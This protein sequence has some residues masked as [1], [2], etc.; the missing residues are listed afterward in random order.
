MSLGTAFYKRQNTSQ[1]YRQQQA[2]AAQQAMVN[3]YMQQAQ[4][5]IQQAAMAGLRTGLQQGVNTGTA[6]TSWVYVSSVSSGTS[7]AAMIPCGPPQIGAPGVMGV[8][9]GVASAVI[10]ALRI[11]DGQECKITLPDNTIV[12]VKADG[13]YELIDKDA[14]VVYRAARVRDFNRFINVSDRIEEFIAFCGEQGVRA[15]EM[16][17]LPISLFI[18]WL[19]IEAAKADKE[20]EPDVKLLPDL[21]RH[22]TARCVDCGRFISPALKQKRIEYCGPGCFER[23][24]MAV[25]VVVNRILPLSLCR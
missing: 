25:A 13:S 6:T 17:N 8:N 5:T 24:F 2:S 19:V 21:R 14:K 11:H 7:T 23:Q 1:I 3:Q 22:S 9:P 16:L 10:D 12:D 15:D 20:P 4:A 18:G